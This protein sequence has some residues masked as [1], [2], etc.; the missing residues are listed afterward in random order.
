MLVEWVDGFLPAEAKAVS[1]N[2]LGG[3]PFPSVRP[4]SSSLAGVHLS[5]PWFIFLASSSSCCGFM[6]QMIDIFLFFNLEKLKFWASRPSLNITLV[7]PCQ[8]VFW[9]PSSCTRNSSLCLFRCRFQR[10]LW[11]SRRLFWGYGYLWCFKGVALLD[12]WVI[13]CDFNCSVPCWGPL[14]KMAALRRPLR[15]LCVCSLE[16]R[17]KSRVHNEMD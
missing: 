12:G 5:R 16:S 2:T 14:K 8:L 4:P 15:R 6:T 13:C 11:Y 10:A 3:Y 17:S 9:A 7:P 1:S